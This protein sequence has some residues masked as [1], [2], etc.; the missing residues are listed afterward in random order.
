MGVV[1]MSYVRMSKPIVLS[2]YERVRDSLAEAWV[3]K[4]SKKESVAVSQERGITAVN[5]D[6]CNDYRIARSDRKAAY[7]FS[8]L[9]IDLKEGDASAL[10][11]PLAYNGLELVAVTSSP[12][13]AAFFV[14][15]RDKDGYVHKLLDRFESIGAKAYVAVSDMRDLGE[16]GFTAMPKSWEDYKLIDTRKPVPLE[17]QAAEQPRELKVHVERKP[18]ELSDLAVSYAA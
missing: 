3:G 7:E 5:W 9:Q 14:P 11:A 12:K 2:I 6:L 8:M 16:E 18:L 17:V 10:F 13:L 4:D 15:A 1:E